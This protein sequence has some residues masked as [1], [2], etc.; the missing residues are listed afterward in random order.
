[1]IRKQVYLDPKHERELKRMARESGKTEA[2][3]IREALD[4][5]I[6]ET[7]L[8]KER[9]EAWNA[10]RAFIDRWAAKGPVPVSRRRSWRREDLYDR[11]GLR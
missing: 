1:M 3:I 11:K 4:R 8:D 6:A 10:E 2:T 7:R 5:L 9:L